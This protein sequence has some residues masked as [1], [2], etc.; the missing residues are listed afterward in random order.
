MGQM[1]KRTNPE[2][3]SGSMRAV[4]F[5][6]ELN[7]IEKDALPVSVVQVLPYGDVILRDSRE[8]FVVSDISV[9]TILSHF[10]ETTVDLA[11]DYDHGMYYGD[12][13]DASGW[14]E[15]MWAVI[16]REAH[17]RIA[18]FLDAYGDR[19][20]LVAS[21]EEEDWGIYVFVRWTE[22]AAEKIRAREYR[23][24]SPVVFFSFTGE[25]EYLWNVA[26]VNN[27][28]IDGMGALAASMMPV[29]R[30]NEE[31]EQA[32]SSAA[33]SD[34]PPDGTAGAPIAPKELQLEVSSMDFKAFASIIRPEVDTEDEGFD[35]ETFVSDVVNEITELRE[36]VNENAAL[37]A[38][39]EQVKADRDETREALGI[40]GAENAELRERVEAFEASS[41][42]SV[43]D[44]A[45]ESGKLAKSQRDW[46][47]ANYPAFEQLLE[48]LGDGQRLG[49]PQGGTVGETKNE[50]D[51]QPVTGLDVPT[52]KSYAKENGLTFEAAY[53]QLKK[54]GR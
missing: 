46:A 11:F 17:D 14:G 23:Y 13:N 18:P 48:T 42:E 51:L 40:A 8:N 34:N 25:A 45:I 7:P 39:F 4:R 36:R 52:I 12:N 43:V 41:R 31:Q 15:K 9:L 22:K 49:P 30:N 24:V 2:R 54:A 1:N 28:A 37:A 50:G 5:Q 33:C 38:E 21:D 44:R 27:P 53:I 16:P 35:A 20:G 19:V 10:G 26:I 6:V 32:E 47:I 3:P 29:E